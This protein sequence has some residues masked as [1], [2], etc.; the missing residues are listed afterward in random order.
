MKLL[1]FSSDPVEVERLS[2]EL[3][4]AGIPCE[5]HT[6]PLPEGVMPNLASAEL[7]IQNERDSHRATMLCVELGAGFAKR[8]R[9]RPSFG[10]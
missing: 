5:V 6:K 1:Y 10:D 4:A 9:T 2:Q 7:W 8:T 3:R